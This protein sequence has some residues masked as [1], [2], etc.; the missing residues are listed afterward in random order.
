MKTE[1]IKLNPQKPDIKAL[2]KAAKRIDAGEIAAFPTETVYGLA[3]RVTAKNIEKLNN[4]KGRQPSKHYTLHIAD[5]KQ[6]HKYVPNISLRVKK[7]IDNTWPGPLTIVFELDNN[8]LELLEKNIPKEVFNNL[9]REKTIGIRC[10]DNLIAAELLSNIKHPVAAPSANISGEAA[11]FTAKQVIADFDGKIEIIL[12]GGHTKLHKSSTVA[13]PGKRQIKILRKGYYNLDALEK[14]WKVQIL[15]VCTGNT[16]RSP[17]AE[18]IFKKRIAENIGCKVDELEQIGYKVISAG[19]MGASGW[20]ASAESVEVCRAN[21]IDISRHTNSALTTE[22]VRQSDL[23]Y[24]MSNAHR[25]QVLALSPESTDKCFL[26]DD[27]KEV[28]DPVSQSIEV[29]NKCFKMI[30]SAIDKRLSEIKL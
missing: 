28:P 18:G 5:A 10:P 20:P 14:L 17:M 4:I 15:T 7:L 3:C 16:C 27:K 6:V 29:Y 2:K 11:P 22:L 26:I 9:Y 21:G 19:T 30:Y 13:K 1:I 8:E 24:T 23:I 25:K 12:D